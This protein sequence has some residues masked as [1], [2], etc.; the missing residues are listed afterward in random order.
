MTVLIA[1][2]ASA[3]RFAPG[4]EVFTIEEFCRAHRI[5]RSLYFRMKWDGYGPRE[6]KV[7]RRVLVSKEAAADWRREREVAGTAA[8]LK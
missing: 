1:Q 6:M 8:S 5:S 3:A 4:G 7:G 2:A